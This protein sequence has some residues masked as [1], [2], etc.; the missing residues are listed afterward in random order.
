MKKIAIFFLVVI[1][2]ITGM[3]YLYLNYKANY[4][5]AKKENAQ[6]V[7]Y[8]NKEIYGAELATILNKAID[9]NTKNDVKKDKKGKYINN[10]NNSINIDIRFTDDD[11]TYNMEK[12]YGGQI[13]KFVSYYNN[14]KFKCTKIEYHS[15]SDKV[16]YMLFEQIT[17]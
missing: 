17:E 9:N 11:T 14:I 3:S 10:N 7:S 2:I 16:K 15:S 12:I 5:N 1:I 6:F 4:E 8:Y 13:E